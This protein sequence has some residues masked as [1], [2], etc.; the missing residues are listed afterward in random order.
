MYCEVNLSQS[1]CVCRLNISSNNYNQVK[2]SRMRGSQ[3]EAGVRFING[4]V[5][6]STQGL[7]LYG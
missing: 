3:V 5:K 4:E 6:W 7:Q 1:K 2:G